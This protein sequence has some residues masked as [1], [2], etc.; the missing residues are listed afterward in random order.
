MYCGLRVKTN[1][2]VKCRMAHVDREHICF[3]FILACVVGKNLTIL[4]LNPMDDDTITQ[5][6]G[7]L[8]SLVYIC[9][10]YSSMIWVG[11]WYW[12]VKSS[13]FYT[14]VC[15]KMRRIFIPEP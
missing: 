12:D 3:A 11:M 8:V 2:H 9:G 4:K 7:G 14:K 10:G 15:Q 1:T 5:G 13:P 6:I